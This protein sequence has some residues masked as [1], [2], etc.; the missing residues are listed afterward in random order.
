MRIIDQKG[1]DIKCMYYYNNNKNISNPG[2][3]LLEGR[4]YSFSGGAI[5]QQQL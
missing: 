2:A 3:M 4:V 5:I 1:D